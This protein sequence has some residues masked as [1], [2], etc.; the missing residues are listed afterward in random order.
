MSL[1]KEPRQKMINI[2]YLVLTALLALNVSSQVLEA[3]KTV[4]TSLETSN[5]NLKGTNSLLYKSLEDLK[6]DPKTAAKAGKWDSIAVHVRTISDS[7]SSYIDTLKNQLIRQAHPQYDDSGKL[8]AFSYDNLEASTRFLEEEKR[9]DTLKDKLV[10]YKAQILGMDTSINAKFKDVLPIDVSLPVNKNKEDTS[11]R[12]FS[13]VYFHMVPTVAALTMLSKFENNIKTSENQVVTFCQDQVGHV[14]LHMDKVGVLTGANSSYLMPGGQLIV[15][16]GVGAY[17][18][19]T[20]ATININGAPQNVVA[21]Q[22]TY[23]T[24]VSGSGDHIVP[25]TVTFLGEDGKPV[26]QT[27]SIKYTVGT[28]GGAAASADQMNVFY[29]GVPNPVTIGSPTGWERTKVSISSGTITSSGSS[30]H[31]VVNETGGAGQTITLTV[32]ADGKTT[33]F[34]FR[35]KRIPNPVFKVGLSSGGSISSTEFKTQQYCRAELENFD[36]N[37]HFSV[38]S[39]TVYF[40]GA[41]FSTPAKADLVG[42]NLGSLDTYINRCGP[43]TSV[44]FDDVNVKGP[45]GSLRTI[46]GPGFFLK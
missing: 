20:N 3:F 28:P 38:I 21:G 43:G 16:A 36:F 46:P 33:P 12:T 6:A 4:N 24:T 19:S 18:S 35:I 13:S 2:M 26:T 22:A 32:D 8:V 5:E 34:P 11:T 9:G 25:I 45:D 37:A 10:S 29:I 39:A 27:T 42:N 1:P 14:V 7:M 40:I 30:G 41:N 44:I 17:S 31:F 15:T 23:T